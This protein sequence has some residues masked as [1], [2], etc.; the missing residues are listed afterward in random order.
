MSE[1]PTEK[2]TFIYKKR[3]WRQKFDDAFRG[4]FQSVRQQSSY[5]V[6]FVFA[7][8]VPII[9]VSLR[10]HTLEWCFIILLI[11]L[12]F[13]AEMLN[14]VFETLSRVITDEYDERVGRA[15]DI[16]SGAVLIISICAAILG[17]VIFV[18]ALLRMF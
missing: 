18:A 15:L 6:H 7:L 1:E 9:G 2:R 8:I 14:S 12:V 11:A 3:T 13:A 10:L 16:A 4:I 17:T 5:R